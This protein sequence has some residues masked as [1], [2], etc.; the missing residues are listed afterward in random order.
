MKASASIFNAQNNTVK[1]LK[2]SGWSGP[3]QEMVSFFFL[4]TMNNG[5]HL[6]K[7]EDIESNV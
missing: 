1:R 6:N 2:K 3:L 4:R 7:A 5:L